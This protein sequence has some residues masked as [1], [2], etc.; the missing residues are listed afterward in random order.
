MLWSCCSVKNRSKRKTTWLV[1]ENLVSFCQNKDP[2]L[3]ISTVKESVVK[4]ERVER[5]S[6]FRVSDAEMP[7]MAVHGPMWL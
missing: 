4:Y 1:L 5:N 6:I 2:L 7:R 3:E